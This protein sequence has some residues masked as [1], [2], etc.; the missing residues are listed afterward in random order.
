MTDDAYWTRSL[1]RAEVS[2]VREEE[3]EPPS[4]IPNEQGHL[5]Y[6][7]QSEYFAERIKEYAPVAQ[8]A[9]NRLIRFFK[10]RLH[11][12]FLKEL[13]LSHQCFQNAMWT[14]LSGKEVGK[15]SAVL[16]LQGTPGL[17]GELGVDK[18]RPEYTESV[19]TSLEYPVNPSLYE[20]FISHAQ[21]ALFE[22]NFKR[23]VL[24]LAIACEIMVK[25]WFFSEDSPAGA[26]FD[27]LEDR[28]QVTVK[29]LDLIDRVA[30]EAFGRSFRVECPDHYRNIDYLFRCRNKVAHRGLLFYRDDRGENH[31]VDKAT[32]ADWW[33]SVTELMNW[34]ESC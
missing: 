19:Q 27:Y 8:E 1:H 17:N 34:I 30:K 29:V 3:V 13:S 32:V 5:D 11:T 9:I 6:T 7:V 24:E 16:V 26:A 33:K 4:V 23:G 12:P 15:G 20:E 10:F 25:R 2:V 28:S 22:G 31:K 18:L 21:S 14:D